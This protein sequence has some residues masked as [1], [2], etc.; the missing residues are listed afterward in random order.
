[1]EKVLKIQENADVNINGFKVSVNG[2]KGTLEKDL[3]SPIFSKLIKIEKLEKAIKISSAVEKKKVKA[4]VGT[5]AAHIKSLMEGVTKGFETKL[6]IVYLHF[7]MTVKV[8]GK[9][10][11]VSNFLG[12]KHPREAEIIGDAKVD[13]KGDEI[14]VSGIDKEAVGQT[15]ANI[16]RATWI[17]AKDRRVFMDGIFKID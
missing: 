7:P 2:P 10:I 17:K 8:E 3:Y 5:I 12:E 13:V 6:K 9:K 14:I 11:L 16:E 4:M 15:A 1:M